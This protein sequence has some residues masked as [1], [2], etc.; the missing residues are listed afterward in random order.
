MIVA[1]IECEIVTAL[2]RDW[3][4]RIGDVDGLARLFLTRFETSGYEVEKI[5][6]HRCSNTF[7]ISSKSHE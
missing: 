4:D 7:V 3:M 6:V 1:L 5:P 2:M